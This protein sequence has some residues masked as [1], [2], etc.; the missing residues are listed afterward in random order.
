MTRQEAKRLLGLACVILVLSGGAFGAGWG[1]GSRESDDENAPL[2]GGTIFGGFVF[3]L[4]LAASIWR[5]FCCSHRGLRVAP[6]LAQREGKDV[7]AL[8]PPPVAIASPAIMMDRNSY[9][10]HDPD[11]AQPNMAAAAA[12]AIHQEEEM[13][14]L[15]SSSLQKAV[16]QQQVAVNASASLPQ[17][18]AQVVGD[19]PATL[20]PIHYAGQFDDGERNY[21]N[22]GGSSAYLISV[23]EQQNSIIEKNGMMFPPPH[24]PSHVIS[25]AGTNT[26]QPEGSSPH[27]NQYQD[28]DTGSKSAP[29]TYRRV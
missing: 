19:A 28:T 24:S 13:A 1:I 3:I 27:H 5:G 11:V 21:E 16:S 9:T 29:V 7:L 10:P 2:I 23:M 15:R 22:I 17:Y 25:V 14:S 6:M 18:P 4:L 26:P 20:P 8:S 12:R